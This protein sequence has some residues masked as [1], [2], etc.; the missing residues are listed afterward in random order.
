MMTEKTTRH[1]PI[2][3]A[4]QTGG[5]V[6]M[7]NFYH[8]ERPQVAIRCRFQCSL[9]PWTIALY[10]FTTIQTRS[11]CVPWFHPTPLSPSLSSSAHSGGGL[12]RLKAPLLANEI[13]VPSFSLSPNVVTATY[14][15][16]R[17]VTLHEGVWGLYR[18]FGVY[19]LHA[20]L[21]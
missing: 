7:G 2:H 6:S 20:L 18:G 19:V 3:R 11:V 1:P 16:L 5:S 4:S 9:S 13:N 14:A 15:S 8:E 10:P 12:C 21:R 17:L